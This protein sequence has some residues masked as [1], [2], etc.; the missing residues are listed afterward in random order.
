MTIAAFP[1]EA[2]FL[3]ALAAAWLATGGDASQGLII[4]P[5]RRSARALAGAFLQANQGQSLLLPRIIAFGAI[6]ETGL[7]IADGL[8]L[9]PAVAPMARQAILTKL[10]LARQG[11]KGA[12]KKLATAWT[13]AGDLA[14]LLDEADAAEIDLRSALPNVVNAGLAAHWQTTLEF[15]EIIT[16]AWPA[17]LCEMGLVNPVDRLRR[18]ID[19]QNAAWQERPP[20][21]KVWMVTH[22]A[23]PVLTRLGKT[24]ATLPQGAVILPSYDTTMFETSWQHVDEGHAQKSI[25]D[26]LAAMGVRHTEVEIWPA[27][28]SAVAPGRAAFLSRA[29][30]PAPCLDIWQADDTEPSPGLFRLATRD[31]HEE[32]TAIAM[33]LRDVLEEH[34][35][36]AALITPDRSLALRVKAVLKRFGIEADDSAGEALADTPP[37]IFLRLLADA[38]ASDFSPVQLLALLKHPLSAAG[39]PPALCREHARF[40]EL[41][42]LRGP[43]PPPGFAGIK[44]HL[45]IAKHVSE[46]DFIARLEGC[47]APIIGMPMAINPAR[48]LILLMTA[49]EN[50]AATD[51]ETGPERLWSGEAGSL[52]ANLMTELLAAFE[53]LPDIAPDDVTG[54]LDAVLVGP[55]VRKPRTKDNH[56]RIAIWGVQEASLQTVDVAVL[57]GLVESVWP[58]PAE[59]GPWLSRP[60]RKA[61]GLPAAERHIGLEAHEFFGLCCRCPTVILSAPVRRQRAPAVPARWITRIDALLAGSRTALPRHPAESWASQLDVPSQRLLR[62]KPFPRPPTSVRPTTLSISDVATLMADPYAIYARKI[63]QLYPLAELDEETDA[64]QFGDIVHHGL[65]AFFGSNPDFDATNA[66]E[67]LTL[68]LQTAMRERRPRAALQHWWEARLQR[69]AWWIVEAEQA[70]RKKHGKPR[71]IGLELSG[72][73]KVGHQFT[74]KGRVDRI[75]QRADG[76]IFI[77]DYKTGAPPSAK[78]VEAG[79]APQLPLEAVMAQAGAFGINFQSK[80]AE[81]AFWQL[82]GRHLAGNEKPIFPK[83]DSLQHVIE[84]ASSQLPLLF[85]KFARSETPYLAAPHPDRS[86]YDDPYLGISRRHEWGGGE[87]GDDR[88]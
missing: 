58:A 40:L 84:A 43:R 7:T 67:R 20:T 53:T 71:E 44:Y 19:A 76:D 75:E 59:P 50:L 25:D 87:D 66:P 68:A 77:M 36:T 27:N 30:L 16:A 55:M 60:M 33:A 31:E 47:L 32:A 52:L 29:L 24:I 64:S 46:R 81:L 28:V 41:A 78:Q 61:A 26:L 22:D 86:T 51:A 2:A 54:L 39:K 4:L 3:P 21:H 56:P 83:S 73:M 42:A 15:L 74:L 23:T 34:G 79:S 38:A 9:P 57:A 10:I 88:A 8:A 48:A 82:S 14:A 35:R 49:A 80:V 1:P 72:I 18:L 85:E 12:P 70:R 37:A 11:A 63:L 62:P 6:D 65:A 13:L 45:E 5:S 17:I 69:I